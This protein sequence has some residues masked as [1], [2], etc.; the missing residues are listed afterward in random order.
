MNDTKINL[1]QSQR[2][3]IRPNSRVGP[4]HSRVE[5]VVVNGPSSLLPL[6]SVRLALIS[7]PLRDVSTSELPMK[8]SIMC[9]EVAVVSYQY[10][11]AIV[12]QF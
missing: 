4:E 6:G 3:R 7:G 5:P 11:K 1:S 12:L 8:L 9:C 2:E 10:M